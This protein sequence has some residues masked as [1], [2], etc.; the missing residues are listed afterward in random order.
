MSGDMANHYSWRQTIV[1]SYGRQGAYQTTDL[2]GPGYSV[3]WL[4]DG[5]KPLTKLMMAYRWWDLMFDQIVI[6]F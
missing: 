6:Y 2:V 1:S 4:P 5:T 3:S